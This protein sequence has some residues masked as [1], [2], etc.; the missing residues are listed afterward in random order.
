MF[1]LGLLLTVVV[2]ASAASVPEPENPDSWK[3]ENL[4]SLSVG[5][6]IVVVSDKIKVLF[7]SKRLTVTARDGIELLCYC[8]KLS[9][10]REFGEIRQ[11]LKNNENAVNEILKHFRVV[12]PPLK[13]EQVLPQMGA[14]V[15]E[16]CAHVPVVTAVRV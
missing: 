11:E 2:M 3:E 10:H 14:T 8:A 1:R 12:W 15:A 6:E 4:P 16:F 5:Q 13:K 9:S 7:D